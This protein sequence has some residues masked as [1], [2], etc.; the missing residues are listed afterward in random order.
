M[1]RSFL[2]ERIARR[3]L[4]GV[5][6]D[7]PPNA[8]GKRIAAESLPHGRARRKRSGIPCLHVPFLYGAL[9][10]PCMALSSNEMRKAIGPRAGHNMHD[11]GSGRFIPGTGEISQVF[12]GAAVIFRGMALGFSCC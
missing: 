8:R 11:R 9:T 5:R 2:C 7:L 4:L 1:G 6:G 10:L 12:G 3:S